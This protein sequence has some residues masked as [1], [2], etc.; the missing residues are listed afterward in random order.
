MAKQQKIYGALFDFVRRNIP[1]GI[2]GGAIGGLFAWFQPLFVVT[3]ILVSY[4]TPAQ[5]NFNLPWFKWALTLGGALIG[6]IIQALIFRR[7]R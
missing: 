3:M 7:R 4:W 5:I 6:M 2:V 1:G